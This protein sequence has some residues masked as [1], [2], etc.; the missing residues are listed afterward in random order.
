MTRAFRWGFTML[1]G[2]L[3]LGTA[4]A[5]A[6]DWPQWRGPHGDAV[7]A[8]FAVPAA[9]PAAFAR[10]WQ[11]TVGTGDATPALVGDRLY[12]FA[13][14]G[15]EEVTLCLNAADGAE[16]WR[17]AYAA[18]AV[19]GAAAQHPGPRGSPAV[20]DGKVVTLGVQFNTPV[21]KDGYLYGLSERGYLFC[22]DA[23]TG[24]TA[25][26]DTVRRGR[27]F[28]AILDAG[29]VLLALPDNATLIAYAPN[30]DAYTELAQIKVADKQTYAYPV[31]AGKRLFV[32]D[33]ETLTLWTVE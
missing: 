5:A 23:G 24:Q 19:T 22:L 11:V 15:A 16:L 14:Q 27:N 6:Q 31:C 1:T 20:A 3:L 33:Q 21:L 10:Q 2:C 13:R 32:R 18:P 30:H 29:P 26:Q 4:R 8:G 17:D 12:V 9:W 25:W 28:A 7:A